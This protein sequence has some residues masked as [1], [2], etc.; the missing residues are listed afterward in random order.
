MTLI[1]T[2]LFTIF[3]GLTAISFIL[4][5]VFWDNDL[6][7]IITTVLAIIT[8]ILLVSTCVVDMINTYW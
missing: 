8:I 3:F 5:V 6:Y 4:T 7:L 2:I 1:L